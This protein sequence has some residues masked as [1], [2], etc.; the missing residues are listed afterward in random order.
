MRAEAPKLDIKPLE[1]GTSFRTLAYTALKQAIMGADIYGQG[2]E[3][4]LDERQLSQ[5]LG[6]SRTP[7]REAMTL[8]EQEGFL[9]TEPRRGV[10]IV[11][12][13]RRQIVEMI[14]VWAA[15]E[16]LSARLGAAR[17]RDEEIAAVRRTMAEFEHEDPHAH[18]D[19]YSD[20]NIA[21]HQAIIRLGGSELVEQI[22]ENLFIHV[23]A[24]RRATIAQDNRVERSIQDHLRIIEALEARAGELAGRLVLEHGLGLAAHVQRNS[25]FLD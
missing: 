14:E 1:T 9:R 11:R 5:A 16:S 3:I 20:A 7:V 18:V 17:A 19:D 21:F 15:L 12:K 10:F 6:V 24:I 22:T 23:R 13:T 4:R 8:L 25:T 2:E